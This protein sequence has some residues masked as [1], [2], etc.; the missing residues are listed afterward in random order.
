LV[1]NFFLIKVNCLTGEISDP[2]FFPPR[3]EGDLSFNQDLTWV[4]QAHFSNDETILFK[5]LDKNSTIRLK[6]RFYHVVSFSMTDK[7]IF[8]VP[9]NS[10]STYVFDA[11]SGDL[12]QELK[13]HSKDI[14]LTKITS[15][16]VGESLM[17]TGS[18][19]SSLRL[20]DVKRISG[21]QNIL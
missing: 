15:P 17:V 5:L 12:V 13:G 2:D 20:Y 19:D 10:F 14:V 18:E 7:W 6:K 1:N 8:I 16:H 4:C 3:A 11:T 9:D 21:S